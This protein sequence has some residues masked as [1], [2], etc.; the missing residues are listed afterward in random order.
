[1]TSLT[2]IDGLISGL[3][4]TEL[5]DAL[6]Q[7]EAAPQTLLK[8]KQT[9][10]TSLVAAMQAL[11]TKVAS[12]ATSA[13]TAAK[14][15]SWNAFKAT[16]SATSVTA[17]ATSSAQPSSLSFTVDSVAA[18]Q[19]S[20]VTLPSTYDSTTP[21]F[22]IVRDGKNVTVTA[23][24][25]SVQD[26]VSAFNGSADAGVKAVAVRVTNGTTPEYRLQITGTATGASNAFEMYL[27][28]AATVQ[29]YLDAPA[30]VPA[31]ARLVD[32]SAAPVKAADAKITM[33]GGYSLT[34][35]TNTFAALMTGVDVTVSATSADPI[36]VTVGQDGAAV[37]A[38]ASSLVAN[39]STVLSEI[40]SRTG[41]TTTTAD[42]GGTIVKGGLFSGNSLVRSVQQSV[43]SEASLPVNGISPSDVG[44]KI[45]RDG[46]FTFDDAVF[47]AA[48]AADPAKVQAVVSGVAQRVADMADSFSH[49]TTGVLTQ[50]VA[51]EQDMVKDL[52]TR[53]ADWDDRLA[54]RKE[55]LQK[56]YAALETSLSKLKSTSSWLSSQLASLPTTSSSK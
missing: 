38:L 56:T 44:I 7:K 16:G 46:T 3:K 51:S 31:G 36:T 34:S 22:T 53:I 41:T 9:A 48:L 33:T 20:S 28:D 42:D 27:G 39:L 55:T 23:A 8:N 35:S 15:S 29:G 24:S 13:A 43:L 2:S 54:I 47:T 30:T 6:L 49:A 17:T 25:T 32:S 50:A 19:T 10:S 40:S 14:A 5:I 21:S 11:N 18:A 45:T 26:I 37:K 1:M 52:T 12:L 4:T